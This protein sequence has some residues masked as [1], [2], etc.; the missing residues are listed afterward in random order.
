MSSPGFRIALKELLAAEWTACPVLDISDW[1]AAGQVPAGLSDAFM[2]LQFIGGPNRIATIGP[3]EDHSWRETGT[4]I[5]HLLFPV[6]ENSERA[7]LWS[8]QLVAMLRGRRLGSYTIDFCEYF[9]DFAGAA[10]RLDGR[11]HG[12]SANLG[13]SNTVCA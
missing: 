4:A 9:T 13:Y 6:G 7:L 2:A 5:M 3:I 1:I 11:W 8:G 12:W 10:I